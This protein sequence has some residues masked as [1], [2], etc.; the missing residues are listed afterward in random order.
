MPGVDRRMLDHIG[1]EVARA[2]SIVRYAPHSHFSPTPMAG[3]RLPGAGRRVPGRAWR[4][5]RRLLRP[6]PADHAAHAG[7][8]TRL[9]DLRQALAVR[10]RR[11]HGGADRTGKSEFK[12][13]S[14]RPG[15]EL[16]PL[17]QDAGEE[18]RLERWTPAAR[19]EVAL[20]QGAEFL[21]LSGSFE[22]RGEIVR[23]AVVAP[24][25][26]QG[27][28]A[29]QGRR[30]RLPRLDQGRASRKRGEVQRLAGDVD[31]LS[32]LVLQRRN[33]ETRGGRRRHLAILA[34]R[35]SGR[36]AD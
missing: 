16:M 23:R 17:F 32:E 9:R 1:D 6:Q 10:S 5:S 4:L 22:E 35:Q 14:G 28:A 29:S 2:T 34:G 31:R 8:R 20:P 18:V 30:R 27:N 3:R 21:V 7:L 25:S 15:V 24:S 26:R 13:A 19:I 36:V 12:P 11:S 33:A